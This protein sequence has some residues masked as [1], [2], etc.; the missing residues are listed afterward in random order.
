MDLREFF[1]RFISVSYFITSEMFYSEIFLYQIWRPGTLLMN[2][3][4]QRKGLSCGG[5]YKVQPA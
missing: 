2:S 4:T 5:L 3:L 1:C